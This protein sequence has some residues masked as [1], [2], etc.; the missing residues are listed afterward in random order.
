MKL[1]IKESLTAAKKLL[2]ES[3]YKA[4]LAILA[5]L[6]ICELESYEKSEYYI[7]L[8]ENLLFLGDYD[9][10]YLDKAINILKGSS[11]H[12]MYA[13]AKYLRGWQQQ[14]LQTWIQSI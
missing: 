2:E 1:Q 13:R 12:E 14:S 7:L 10:D 4:S 6:E 9:Q 8:G 5:N 11:Y 3:N